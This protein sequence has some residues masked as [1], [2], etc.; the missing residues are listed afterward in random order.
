M[1]TT[2]LQDHNDTGQNKSTVK[3]QTE[4]RKHL[5][6]PGYRTGSWTD[7]KSCAQTPDH[8]ISFILSWEPDH[9]I[10]VFW[11]NSNGKKCKKH[12][13]PC[14][15]NT[16]QHYMAAHDTQCVAALGAG[17]WA[18]LLQ[19]AFYDLFPVFCIFWLGLT[20][21]CG[22]SLRHLQFS[23]H[24][25]ILPHE[26]YFAMWTNGFQKKIWGPCPLF[27]P[28]DILPEAMKKPRATAA[29]FFSSDSQA[30]SVHRWLEMAG[31]RQL[32]LK[33]QLLQELSF[34]CAI[35]YE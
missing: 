3:L 6:L 10:A 14:W 2:L 7:F 1:S 8:I 15:W 19:R 24:G 31:Y 23:A 32:W 12:L 17:A 16:D 29:Y 11:F 26:R 33:F 21:C 34:L 5:E 35:S 20:V 22:P 9:N 30:A 27:P 18:A 25:L 4:S 13:K 28:W